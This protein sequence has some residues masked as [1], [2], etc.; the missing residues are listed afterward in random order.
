MISI[1][2]PTYNNEKTIFDSINSILNQNYC[3]FELIIINDFSTD[4]TKQIIKSFNDN[5]IIYLE[6]KKNIG[7]T[8]SI[9][10][11]IDKAKGDYIAR[12]DGDDISLPERLEIQLNYL[13]LNPNIDLVA[14][15]IILFTSNKV[16]GNSKLELFNSNNINFYMR[17]LGLPHMTWMT[18]AEFFKNFKYNTYF[19]VAQDQDLL[20]RANNFCK[21]AL[22][23]DPLLFVRIPEKKNVKYKLKQIYN[24]LLARIS[25]LN[26]MKLFYYY[27]LILISFIRSAFYYIF[28]SKRIDYEIN[29]NLNSKY[30]D[31]LDKVTKN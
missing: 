16:I 18:K 19:K 13:I 30:Q 7:S 12:M 4:K 10:R 28:S 26:N 11:G 31:I 2:L 24:L 23:K 14:S 5:R 27:P 20:L 6:N 1:I 21:F 8:K 22:L 29:T 25:Y 9:L 17:T 15:N 3:N